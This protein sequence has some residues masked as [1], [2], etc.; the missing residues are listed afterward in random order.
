MSYYLI[1]NFLNLTSLFMS[2]L[3]KEKQE[4]KI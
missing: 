3:I 1:E 4:T 2:N